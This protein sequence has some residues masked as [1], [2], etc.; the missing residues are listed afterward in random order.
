[1]KFNLFIVLFISTATFLS[2]KEK[3]VEKSGR[4]PKWVNTLEKDY[5]IT[6][7][8]DKSLENAKIKALAR[9][10]EQ[11][12]LSI[13][14]NIKTKSESTTEETTLN[15]NLGTFIENFKSTTTSASGKTDYVQGISLQKVSDFYWEKIYNKKEKTTYYNYHLK[16]PFSES[17]LNEIIAN[18]K[19]QDEE[20]TRKMEDA[21]STISTSNSVEEILSAQ[22]QLGSLRNSFVDLRQDKATAGV[23]EARTLLQNMGI[24]AVEH[25]NGTLVFELRYNGKTYSYN[26]IPKVTS[27]CAT[28]ENVAQDGNQITVKYNADYCI[29]EDPKNG[30]D[31]RYQFGTIRVDKK[32]K[33]SATEGKVEI[34]IKG[35]ILVDIDGN[36]E[37]PLYSKYENSF[38]IIDIILE[39]P[40]GKTVKAM[41][42]GGAEFS[43]K[44]IIK[45][46]ANAG[47]LELKQSKGRMNGT[48]YYRSMQ[49]GKT[50]QY[51]FYRSSYSKL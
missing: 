47:N 17:E 25:Q 18:Y 14:D 39:T 42:S 9:V 6:M 43:Q 23:K 44:G 16:Y 27:T 33:F 50:G 7:A 41:V 40:E 26:K 46:L 29:E 3:I 19:K 10:K 38:E 1:M 24:Q 32:F 51:K 45:L 36:L 13:A 22:S 28:I 37:I 21:L 15:K 11:I 5:I 30:I 12:V 31:V 48:I 35:N 2:A 49:T 34:F 20:L 4:K 8:S